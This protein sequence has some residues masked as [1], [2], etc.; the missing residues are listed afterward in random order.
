MIDFYADKMWG[1]RRNIEAI[2]GF[3]PLNSRTSSGST[4]TNELRRSTLS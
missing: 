1:H 4:C 2:V 3:L